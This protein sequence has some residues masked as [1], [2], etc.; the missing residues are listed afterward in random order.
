MDGNNLSIHAQFMRIHALFH[1]RRVQSHHAKGPTGDPYRGQGRVLRLLQMRPE[2]SQK[3]L[4]FLLD[5]RPQSL[6]EVLAK[7]ER[8]AYIT[9]TTLESDRRVMN[10]RL[11]EKGLEAANQVEQSS[12]PDPLFNCLSQEE[13]VKLGEYLDRIII[14]M[15]KQHEEETKDL[16][17]DL[18]HVRHGHAFGGV[19]HDQGHGHAHG[20]HHCRHRHG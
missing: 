4:T 3:D 11:T 18:H 12:E 16:E 19:C 2:I 6:G 1:R 14:E 13:Q 17:C 8:N 9:R 7:L 15:E 5:M 10:I 20:H